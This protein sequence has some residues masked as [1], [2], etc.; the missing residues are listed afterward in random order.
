M[1]SVLEVD[2]RSGNGRRHGA[3]VCQPE[4]K[5]NEMSDIRYTRCAHH[6]LLQFITMSVVKE[7]RRPALK[8][9]WP[10]ACEQQATEK[11]MG[12]ST[13]TFRCFGK[14]GQLLL[15]CRFDAGILRP[16]A[17]QS[18]GVTGS[19]IRVRKKGERRRG[20]A[21]VSHEHISNARVGRRRT[22]HASSVERASANATFARFTITGGAPSGSHA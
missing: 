14:Q 16:W 21:Y 7:N 8:W 20:G 19:L 15:P 22:C 12:N 6:H 18:Q 1:E 17:E 9:K 3:S 2:V 4:G 10:G 5:K 11:G 13:A